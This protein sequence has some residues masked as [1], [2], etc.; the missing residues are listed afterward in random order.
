MSLDEL[1]SAISAWAASALPASELVVRSPR[2]AAES[3]GVS[4]CVLGFRPVNDSRSALARRDPVIDF[5]EAELALVIGPGSGALAQAHMMA[6]LHFAALQG[7]P[8]TVE[9]SADARPVLRD[10]GLEAALALVI[11]GRIARERVTEPIPVVREAVFHLADRAQAEAAP[12][13]E[14]PRS[15]AGTRRRPAKHGG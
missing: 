12:K 1:V 7:V 15:G 5:L 10:L 4:L 11:R 6:Q 14:R 2:E 9:A 13:H 8:F 3:G